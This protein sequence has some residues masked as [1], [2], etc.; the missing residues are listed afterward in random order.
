MRKKKDTAQGR[1][2]HEIFFVLC[3]LLFQFYTKR[4]LTLPL[5]KLKGNTKDK[6]TRLTGGMDSRI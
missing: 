6:E 4:A 1:Q 3:V 5:L 2:G